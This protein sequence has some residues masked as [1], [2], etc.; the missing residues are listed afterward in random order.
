MWDYPGQELPL[1]ACE[2]KQIIAMTADDV[3]F[4]PA[5]YTTSMGELDSVFGPSERFRSHQG[6][7]PIRLGHVNA[8][9]AVMA[10]DQGRIPPEAE[11][12]SPGGFE[13]LNPGQVTLEVARRAAAV[14]PRASSTRWSGRRVGTPPR[15]SG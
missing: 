2:V 5:Y 12:H 10:V 11:I 14:R 6:W 7:I 8:Y 9:E 1:S 3:D 15:T 4:S 13:P